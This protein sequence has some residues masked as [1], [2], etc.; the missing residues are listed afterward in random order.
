MLQDRHK[1]ECYTAVVVLAVCGSIRL[2]Q[3]SAG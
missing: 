2:S 3:F 1:S